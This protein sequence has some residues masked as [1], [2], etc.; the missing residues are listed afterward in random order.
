MNIINKLTIRQ[1]KLNKK[2]TLVTIIG[3]IISVAMVTAVATLVVSF[4]DLLQ[5]QT[6]A[7]EGEWHVIYKNVNKEQIQAIYNHENTKNLIL[8]RDTGFAFLD[9]SQNKNKPY[10]FIKEYNNEG[11]EKFPVKLKEGRFSQKPD[12]IVISEAI[13]TNGK[14]DY[15]IGDSLSLD[16]GQRRSLIDPEISI[17]LTQN[18]SLHRDE[19]GIKEILE[20][21]QSRQYTIVGI[22][23]RPSWEPAWSPGYTALSYIDEEYMSS[24]TKINASVVLNEINDK[25][26]DDADEL[27]NSNGISEVEFNTSLLRYYGVIRNEELRNTLINLSVIIIG[28]IM[29][30]SI[31]LIYNAFAISVSERSRHLGMMSSVGA[32]KKQK[33]NSVLFEGFTIGLISIP[34]GIISGFAGIGITF[35]FINPVLKSA[36]NI[37]EGFRLV[38]MPSSVI[39]AVV[40]SII[41][42][43]ISTYIPARKASN[44][45]AIDAIR[46]TADIK[47]KGRQVKT[48]KLTRKIFG[49]EGDLGLKNLKRNRTKYKATVFSLIISMVLF[50][51]VSYF[52]AALEKALIM[53][54]EGVNFDIQIYINTDGKEREEIVQHLKTLDNINK[55]VRVDSI[56]LTSWIDEDSVAD[57]VK[58]DVSGFKDGKYQYVINVHALDDKNL[59]EYAKDVGVDY[60]LLKDTNNL[61]A[62]VIDTVQYKDFST[63]KYVESKAI[64]TSPGERI[65]LIY[66]GWENEEEIALEQIEIAALTDKMPMGITPQGQNPSINIIVSK[67]SLDKIVK[68]YEK[69]DLNIDTKLF[70][71]SNAPLKLQEAIEEYEDFIGDEKFHAFNVYAY[72]QREEQML[73]LMSVFVYGF[74]TLISAICTANIFNTISTSIALRKREFAMLKSVGMTPKSFNKMI[75]YESIFYGLKAL[76]YGLPVSFGVMYLIHRSMDDSFSFTLAI[77]WFDVVFMVVA[78]FVIVGMSMLYSG[79]KIKKENIIDI[80]K[81]E[82]I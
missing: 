52:T 14:V 2:R 82:I 46:Q 13:I 78:V 77:P 72:R 28:I 26:F 50:L 49:I 81:Q 69:H 29:I 62:I 18:S 15:Q 12:E 40:V 22:I 37:T 47:I 1:L 59:E 4:M 55:S 35:F 42:I 66:N 48:S 3:V 68:V 79:S 20:I 25:L 31:S 11:F 6:I 8:S 58:N 23:E 44:I 43:L 21:Q 19:E 16:I 67:E 64:K 34:I 74:I 56:F 51:S 10:I 9:G 7:T 36:M 17:E 27:A 30:G 73:L 54:Q 57:F 61:K 60:S 80:L 63:Q 33:R 32:T 39:I 41:T 24:D 70:M 53:S 75:N 5:R 76:L 45:S 71:T 38:I 65:S